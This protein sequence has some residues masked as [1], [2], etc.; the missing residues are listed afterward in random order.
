MEEINITELLLQEKLHFCF[1]STNISC[2]KNIRSS[3]AYAALYLF[4]LTG[5]L[6][7]ICGNLLVIIS[8]S[9]FK[10]L[11]TPTNFLVLSLAITDFLLGVC[12]MPISMVRTVETCWYFG[13]TVCVIHSYFDFALCT[14]S[15]CHLIFISIDRYHAVCNPL[16]YSSKITVY[17]AL[18]FIFVGWAVPLI[19]TAGLFY[20]KGNLEGNEDYD[21]CPG[22]CLVLLNSLWGVLDTLLTFFVPC[23]IMLNVYGKI[24]MVAKQHAIAIRSITNWPV[25]EKKQIT[26][27]NKERKATKT[28]GIVMGVFCLCW[29]PFFVNNLIAPYIS[30]VTPPMIVD[31]FG[32]L[33][34]FNSGFNPIIYGFFYPW[35]RK[36]LKIIYTLEIFKSDSSLIKLFP[37]I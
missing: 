10:Q 13:N 26:I 16:F 27:Q 11:H 8:V 35:F 22:D 28:L 24:F 9:H 31:A 30:L 29:L 23:L 3:G 37:D 36:A 2:P 15:I 1:K 32:W 12:V 4:F 33:G 6:I 14:I 17:V 34:Y 21:P 5:T 18:F 7:T 19:Y 25:N 20:F